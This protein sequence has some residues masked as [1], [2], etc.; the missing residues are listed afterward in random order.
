MDSEGHTYMV[1]PG[2]EEADVAID[3]PHDNDNHQL[4]SSG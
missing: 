2:P 1:V 4:T 3:P